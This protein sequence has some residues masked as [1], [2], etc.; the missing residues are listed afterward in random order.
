MALLRD[1][2]HQNRNHTTS[3]PYQ[4]DMSIQKVVFCHNILK[5]AIKM[6]KQ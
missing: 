4:M 2:W 3:L 5:I 6:K 1:A